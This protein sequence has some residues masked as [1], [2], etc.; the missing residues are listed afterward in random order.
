MSIST[1]SMSNHSPTRLASARESGDD[2][3][4]GIT[5]PTTPSLPAARTHRAATTLLS[6][7]PDKPTTN[8]FFR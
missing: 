4:S 1:V 6:T 5:S 3:R 2:S 7:P 8:P